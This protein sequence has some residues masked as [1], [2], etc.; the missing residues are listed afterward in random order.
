MSSLSKL[1]RLIYISY[2][3]CE[4][5]IGVIATVSIGI[6]L[7]IFYFMFAIVALPPEYTL[8]EF[9]KMSMTLWSMGSIFISVFISV[10]LI[11]LTLSF[12]KIL[13]IYDDGWNFIKVFNRQLL[14]DKKNRWNI[15]MKH[16]QMI[17]QEIRRLKEEP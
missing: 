14:T 5:T 16:E 10:V 2:L 8:E 1:S 3:N 15:K 11:T 17:K 6:V 12:F 13:Y 4:Q 7:G 9:T